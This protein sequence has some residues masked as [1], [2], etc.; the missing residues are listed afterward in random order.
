MPTMPVP[1][2][3][4]PIDDIA[5][6]RVALGAARCQLGEDVAEADVNDTVLERAKLFG[7]IYEL[8]AGFGQIGNAVK[9]FSD[10]LQTIELGRA[11]GIWAVAHDGQV[12]R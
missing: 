5:A 9:A 3:K 1:R 7:P 2:G 6:D 12:Y 4:H 10:G 11:Q 8:R